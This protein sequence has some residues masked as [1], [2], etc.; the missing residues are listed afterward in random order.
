MFFSER[1]SL[2]S[3]FLLPFLAGGKMEN[4]K[5]FPFIFPFLPFNIVINVKVISD[6]IN[7]ECA[8]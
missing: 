4:N 3:I 2:R 1:Y 7:V 6:V 8:K 5:Q